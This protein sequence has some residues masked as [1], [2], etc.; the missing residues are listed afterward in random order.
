MFPQDAGSE[1]S[2]LTQN[3]LERYSEPN[4]C[5]QNPENRKRPLGPRLEAIAEQ[6]GSS[7]SSIKW[8]YRVANCPKQESGL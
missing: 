3:D 7:R 1:P 8:L 6:L 2:N 5:V 4:S